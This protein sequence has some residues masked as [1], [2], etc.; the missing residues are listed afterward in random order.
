M[1]PEIA[2]SSLFLAAIVADALT[3]LQTTDVDVPASLR[4]VS[5]TLAIL[6][7][8]PVIVNA[9]PRALIVGWLQRPLIGAMLVVA[10]LLGKHHGGLETRAADALFVLLCGSATVGLF[11]SGGVDE[12]AKLTLGKPRGAPSYMLAAGLLLLANARILRASLMH[13]DEVINFQ[14]GPSDAFNASIYATTGYAHASDAVT[15]AAAFGS[16][17]GIG[18]SVILAAH[19]HELGVDGG[20]VAIQAAISSAFQ[21]ASAGVVATA[22]DEQAMNLPVVFDEASCTSSSSAC[23][24]A[25][26]SRRL[27]LASSPSTAL[28][29]SGLGLLALTYHAKDP[30]PRAILSSG[31]FAA[32]VAFAITV[33][34]MLLQSPGATSTY[35]EVAAEV[36]VAIIAILDD[37]F[38]GS[39]VYC[40]AAGY[41]V[42]AEGVH[43]SVGDF[44]FIGSLGLLA[45]H[46][47]LT[48]LYVC[49]RP[50]ALERV[51]AVVA[52]A[53]TSLALLLAVATCSLDVAY[54]GAYDGREVGWHGRLRFML[55]VLAWLPLRFRRIEAKQ[56]D[57]KARLWVWIFAAAAAAVAYGG[58]ALAAGSWG[59]DVDLVDGYALWVSSVAVAFVPWLTA[60]MV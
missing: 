60:S 56:L 14:I 16:T 21:M 43:V 55:P 40:I 49:W 25:M 13:A 5:M 33:A 12:Q 27:A 45:V 36:G 29:L 28:W 9:S 46:V 20:C 3:A 18:T 31:V 59:P 1:K 42:A 7:A 58:A 4:G 2:A 52:V 34:A 51:V 24:A 8:S 54:S 17:V 32:L 57:A 37:H 15:L 23:D 41:Q 50:R 11:A 39:I 38:V 44:L 30:Y 19:A 6:F 53:G 22:A 48:T 47:T 26:A 10:C 35:V